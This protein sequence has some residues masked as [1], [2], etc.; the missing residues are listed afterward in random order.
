MVGMVSVKL[1]KAVTIEQSA[2]EIPRVTQIIWPIT[3]TRWVLEY[4]CIRV[5]EPTQKSALHFYGARYY[6]WE[7]VEPLSVK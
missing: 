4:L 7:D 5:L 3:F 2:Q 1:L 6:A